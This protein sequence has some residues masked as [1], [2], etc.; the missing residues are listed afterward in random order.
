MK[1]GLGCMMPRVSSKAPSE[2]PQDHQDPLPPKK[3]RASKS[4]VK[5]TVI[6]MCTVPP[7]TT[8]TA[9]YYCSV[10]KG[11]TGHIRRKQPELAS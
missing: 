2:S 7:K 1:H 4:T 8:V 6:Y 5:F 10:L 9:T 3:A 11:I